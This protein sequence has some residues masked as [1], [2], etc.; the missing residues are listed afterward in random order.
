MQPLRLLPILLAVSIGLHAAAAWGSNVT[1]NPVRVHLSAAKRSELL[2]LRNTGKSAARFQL[3]AHVWQETADGQMKLFATGDLL[4]FPSLFEL[5][6]GETRR[7]RLASTLSAVAAERTYRIIAA[8]LP[9]PGGAKGVV[10]V[11]TKLNIPVFVQAATKPGKP[12]VSARM[13]KGQLLVSVSNQGHSYFKTQSV[14]VVARS[15]AGVPVYEQTLVGW[16]VL[17]GGRRDYR[18]QLP[19]GSCAKIASVTTTVVTENGKMKAS[20]VLRV[21]PHAD[22]P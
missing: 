2:L 1:L 8:E 3:S 11:L 13:D 20:G 19:K 18:L 12:G 4:F 17:A 6:P 10:Q 16:Y 22:C 5:K 15:A 9:H 21:Q 14:R 7:V